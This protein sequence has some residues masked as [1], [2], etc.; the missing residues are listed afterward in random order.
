[1]SSQLIKLKRSSCDLIVVSITFFYNLI[2]SL[3]TYIFNP[4]CILILY[5]QEAVPHFI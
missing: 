5:F 3:F 4:S 1:M 2:R